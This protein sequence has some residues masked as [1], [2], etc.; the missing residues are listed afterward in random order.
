MADRRIGDL[1]QL[2]G[3]EF[4]IGQLAAMDPP[5]D[6]ERKNLRQAHQAAPDGLRQDGEGAAQDAAQQEHDQDPGISDQA[7]LHRALLGLLFGRDA[8]ISCH[9]R[10]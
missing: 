5:H 2:A 1:F 7:E 9:R 10:A 8:R 4:E 6:H 3:A